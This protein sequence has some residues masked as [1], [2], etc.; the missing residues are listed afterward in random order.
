MEAIGVKQVQNANNLG[1]SGKNVI[2]GVIDTGIDY[3]NSLFLDDSGK[4]R[5]GVIWDQT[6]KGL[7]KSDENIEEFK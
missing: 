5:I 3:Q 7:G 6:I 4:S 2:V 1:L